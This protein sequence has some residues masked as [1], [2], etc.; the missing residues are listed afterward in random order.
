[1]SIFIVSCSCLHGCSNTGT[2]CVTQLHSMDMIVYSYS[3]WWTDAWLT[4]LCYTKKEHRALNSGLPINGQISEMAG[5]ILNCQIKTNWQAE[6]YKFVSFYLLM[7]FLHLLVL[8]I[9]SMSILKIITNKISLGLGLIIYLFVHR[10]VFLH[11]PF[12]EPECFR[13]GS[14][15]IRNVR[16]WYIWPANKIWKCQTIFCSIF[17]ALEHH[18]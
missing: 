1:L 15:I 8:N 12:C 16:P 5:I 11:F 10:F 2:K 14:V 6:L 17:W 13:F 7:A 9:L 18:A 4:W 3:T